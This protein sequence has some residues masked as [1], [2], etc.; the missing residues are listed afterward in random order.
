MNIVPT[1]LELIFPSMHITIAF[2]G[3]SASMITSPFFECLL[4]NCIAIRSIYLLSYW[5]NSFE[6]FN[7][8]FFILWKTILERVPPKHSFIFSS[9]IVKHTRSC[10]TVAV[11]YLL[12]LFLNVL[13]PNDS[14]SPRTISFFSGSL[15]SKLTFP[16]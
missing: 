2:T 7:A 8:H 5:W 11:P 6:D 15:N 4:T 13:S 3:L 1:G 10:S 16:D 9:L 14:S 12:P